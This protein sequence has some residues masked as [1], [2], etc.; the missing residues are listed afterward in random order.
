MLG[1]PD[2]QIAAIVNPY[3]E[4]S[5]YFN[6]GNFPPQWIELKLPKL[7]TIHNICLQ[8]RQTPPGKTIHKLYV[9]AA[10]N[11]TKL[12]DTLAGYTETG[13][14]LNLTYSPSLTNVRYLRLHTVLSPSW[15]A[16]SKFLVY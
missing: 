9:G 6:A 2:A 1:S 12:I 4:S 14:W 7:Y 10:S 15:V 11:P 8:V 13:Q 5:T 16:W 3:T